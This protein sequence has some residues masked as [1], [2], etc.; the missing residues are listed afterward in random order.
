MLGMLRIK[1]LPLHRRVFSAMERQRA[2]KTLERRR[3]LTRING[4]EFFYVAGSTEA[5]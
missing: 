3:A 4:F 1:R 2:F 5:T